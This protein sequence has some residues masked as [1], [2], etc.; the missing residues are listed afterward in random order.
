MRKWLTALLGALTLCL[1]LS[2]PA[3]AQVYTFDGPHLSLDLPED[4]YDVVLTPNT[5]ESQAGYLT[6]QGTT[7]EA[8]AA[9]FEAKG[10]L[11]Q[12]VDTANNRTLV[13]T[14][15]QTVDAQMYFDLNNQDEN[16]RREFRVS[17]TNG[18]AYGV[19]GY[20]Y[21]TAT[22]KNYGGSLLRFLRAK[23]T[24]KVGNETE[25]SGVQR[26]TIRN[27]YTITLDLQVRGRGLKDSDDKAMEKLMSGLQF[28]QVLDMPMLPTKLSFS[29]EPPAS[30]ASDT[31]TL[32]GTSG[33][34]A[35]VTVTVMSLTS[36]SSSVFTDT[37]N[38]SGAFSVKVTLPSEGVYTLT[39]TAEAADSLRSQVSYTVTYQKKSK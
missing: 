20:N 4:T 34:K 31:F 29:A 8:M 33:K 1:L 32:K 5:L 13:V 14:A 27:G 19:L 7:V 26:R 18:S 16:M 17:H 9:E 39:V 6:A 38:S 24:L 30:T 35:E 11:L 22:W 23:Y 3:L 15:L 36:T 37:A 21:S 10:I 2:V 28:T 12:A 25:C